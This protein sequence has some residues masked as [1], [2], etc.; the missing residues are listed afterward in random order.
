MDLPDKDNRKLNPLS[1]QDRVL[2]LQ[3]FMSQGDLVT[4]PRDLNEL[5]KDR[6][7]SPFCKCIP[8]SRMTHC[9]L[10]KFCKERKIRV[11]FR[12]KKREILQILKR[13]G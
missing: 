12:K 6:K 8:V 9:D 11:S 1:D 13:K 3:Q 7:E 4:R 10:L 2:R 5:R